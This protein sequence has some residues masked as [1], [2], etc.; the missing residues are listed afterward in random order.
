MKKQQQDHDNYTLNRNN[1][2]CKVADRIKQS[3]LFYYYYYY[4]WRD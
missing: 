2:K 1:V 4:T 3:V